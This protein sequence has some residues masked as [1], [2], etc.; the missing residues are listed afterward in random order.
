MKLSQNDKSLLFSSTEIPDTFF[1]EYLPEASGNSIKVYFY[2]LFLSKYNKE[3]KINDLSKTLSLDFPDVQD[4]IKFWEDKG[5][6]VKKTDGYTLADIR[7]I[8][9]LKLYTPKVTSSPEDAVKSSQS[10]ARARVIESINAQFF[11]GVMSPSWYNDIDLW[12]N[13]YGFDEQVMLA[14]FNYAYDKR[15]LHRNYIQATA[16]AWSKNNIKTFNELDSYF[17]KQEKRTSINGEIAKKLNLRR[18]LTSYEEE[19]IVKWT[20]NYGYPIEIIEIA[21]KKASSNNKVRFDY[22]DALLTDW[23][24]KDLHSQEE[25]ETYLNSIKDKDKKKAQVEKSAFEYTQST[26]DNLDSLYDN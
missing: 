19:D 16:D 18:S 24:A 5:I 4:A 25:V 12:F 2:M 20:E 8:E 10:Q 26:F 13:K 17:E 9:L 7:E 6:L 14:L 3:I 22:I 11:S 21:L 1:T 23:H 15:A